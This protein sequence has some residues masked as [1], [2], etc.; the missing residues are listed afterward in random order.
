MFSLRTMNPKLQHSSLQMNIYYIHCCNTGSMVQQCIPSLFD[1]RLSGVNFFLKGL[2]CKK[3]I[4]TTYYTAVL[5]RVLMSPILPAAP[6]NSTFFVTNVTDTRVPH[7]ATLVKQLFTTCKS[8]QKERQTER[9][10]RRR[11]ERHVVNFTTIHHHTCPT[12]MT[13]H[14][15]Y[16]T[17]NSSPHALEFEFWLRQFSSNIPVRNIGKFDFL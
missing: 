11:T 17:R 10:R 7:F 16:F 14:V 1:M 6:S 12:A 4:F 9:R 2:C 15:V 8:L 13:Y 5:P 3:I